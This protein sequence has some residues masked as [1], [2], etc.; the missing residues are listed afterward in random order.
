MSAVVMKGEQGTPEW[1]ALRLAIPTASCFERIVTASGSAS[2]QAT[3]YM[4]E[5]VSEWVLGRPFSDW[6]GND[7]TERGHEME[8]FARSAY[9]II[10]GNTA[11]QVAF[12]FR[13]DT[14][15]VGCSPDGLLY[16]GSDLLGG[17]EIKC[18]REQRFMAYD[19]AGACP[20]AYIPQVQG[21]M[22]VTGTDRW[23]F[24]AYH[25]NWEPFIINVEADEKFQKA[26]DKH[27]PLFIEQMLE[28]R[29]EPRL[30]AMRERRLEMQGE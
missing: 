2:S 18:P 12:V 7:D 23:A 14:R 19:I 17:L 13:D 11:H 16:D 5:L 10:S 1:H 4:S 6:E 25:E 3:A 29:N 20:K 27:V 22:W 8:P 28:K 21:S 24:V 9:E 30:R 15:L 26:L